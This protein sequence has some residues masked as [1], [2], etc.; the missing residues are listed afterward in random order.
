MP[1]IKHEPAP[2][3]RA[4][5][6][7]GS[8]ELARH[9]ERS[10]KDLY[11]QALSMV[12]SPDAAEDIV[13]ETYADTIAA[14]KSGTEI[15]N[16][17]GWLRSCIHY[18]CIKHRR[19]KSTLQL[20]DEYLPQETASQ[21]LADMAHLRQRWEEVHQAVD[22]L[23]VAQRSALLLA[24]V[25]GLSY[26]EIADALAKSENSVRMLLNR[27]RAFVRGDAGMD[28]VPAFA[29]LLKAHFQVQ[30]AD[31][32]SLADRMAAR[33]ADAQQSISIFAGRSLESLIV[34]AHPSTVVATCAAVF[35]VCAGLG[36]EGSLPSVSRGAVAGPVAGI[37]PDRRES[38]VD[39]EQV[40]EP[41]GVGGERA[42]P[43]EEAPN[44]PATDRTKQ[45]DKAPGPV[46]DDRSEGDKGADAQPPAAI[47]TP[48]GG[49]A[50]QVVAAG[51]SPT[52]QPSATTE[53]G[54]VTGG[55]GSSQ[56]DPG[57]GGG[58]GGTIGPTD[59]APHGQRPPPPDESLILGSGMRDPCIPPSYPGPAVDIPPSGCPQ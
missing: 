1:T 42:Q 29:P 4:R 45:P 3:G 58:P 38:V 7:P 46:A 19:R 21:S 20:T 39:A 28:R 40:D 17:G 44:A 54:P 23:P 33:V 14:I 31:S 8:E 55:G 13:Q 22:Q 53:A 5:R 11:L 35:A 57:S 12:R 6:S 43:Q 25:Y 41:S 56:P 26:R 24:E 59:P 2:P 10:Y 51:A 37:A 9:I 52:I 30:T 16:L 36:G 34:A 18:R 27:A 49:P 48:G 47:V 50:A 15:E 32:Y